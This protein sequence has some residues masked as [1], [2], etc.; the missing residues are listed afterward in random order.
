MIGDVWDLKR[1]EVERSERLEEDD[2]GIC[3]REDGGYREILL[4]EDDERGDNKIRARGGQH[5]E[6]M[7]LS[8][9]YCCHVWIHPLTLIVPLQ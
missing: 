2:V 8:M 6:I 7:E 5:E 9:Q 3:I 1:E 4:R